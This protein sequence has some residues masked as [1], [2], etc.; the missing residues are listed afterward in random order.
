[1]INDALDG[2]I[3]LS[4]TALARQVDGARQEYLARTVH[5]VR[6]PLTAL[7]GSLEWAQRLLS[8]PEPNIAGAL[9]ALSRAQA[10]TA[11][12]LALLTTLGD[13]AR[14][15]LG[16]ADLHVSRLDLIAVMEAAI[17][18]LAPEAAARV[19]LTIPNGTLT[20]GWWDR[21]ALDRVIDNLLSNALKYAP[22]GTPV[23]ITV[24]SDDVLHVSVTDRGIGLAPED[25][26]RLFE[27]YARASGALARSIPGEGLGLYLCRGLVEAHGGRIWAESPGPGQGATIHVRLPFEVPQ[28]LDARRA[29]AG[30][31][32]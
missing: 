29:G 31:V 24:C 2:A 9:D 6:Q 27:R 10:A 17:G 15:A 25:L 3:T 23:D 20:T 4:I 21:V 30:D 12:T 14:L 26:E 18:R 8:R 32:D 7:S 22:A 13:V 16:L 5:D 28:T 1:M 11:Q 19:R